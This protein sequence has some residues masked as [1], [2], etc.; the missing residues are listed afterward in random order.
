MARQTKTDWKADYYRM[1]YKAAS[2]G[3]HE[4]MR[5]S[6]RG[7]YESLE[8]WYKPVPDAGLVLTTGDMPEPWVNAG[9]SVSCA[10][11]LTEY[12]RIVEQGSRRLPIVTA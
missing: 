9:I 8:L 3:V 4:A 5:N 10:V 2:D 6:N 12:W 7:I 11:P 1:V